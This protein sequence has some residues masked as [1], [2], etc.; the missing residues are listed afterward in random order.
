MHLPH[1]AA[2]GELV[3]Y[4]GNGLADPQIRIDLDT[5]VPRLAVADRHGEE[6]L[7]TPRLLAQGLERALPQ[8]RQLHLAHRALHA[9]QQT[10]VRQP[11][12][13][14]PVLIGQ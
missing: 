5:I 4:Q 1:A 14:D 9:E 10:V 2:L 13:I 12:V 7:A 8:Q 3:K 6:Q 11:R